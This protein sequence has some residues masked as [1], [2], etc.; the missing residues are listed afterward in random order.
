MSKL[1]DADALGTDPTFGDTRYRHPAER[2]RRPVVPPPSPLHTIGGIPADG[3]D[4]NRPTM[5]RRAE[6][7]AR[8]AAATV[9]PDPAAL[10]MVEEIMAAVRLR[11]V[12]AVQAYVF[13]RETQDR[14]A[15]TAA[16]ASVLQT[17]TDARVEPATSAA[18]LAALEPLIASI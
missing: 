2:A 10:A 15:V 16:V 1:D 13:E 7:A 12:D 3:A 11:V 18:V 8:D 5:I 17:L 6:A 14:R 9:K 4:L